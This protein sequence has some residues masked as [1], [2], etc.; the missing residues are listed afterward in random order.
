MSDKGV[1]HGITDS[2]LDEYSEMIRQEGGDIVLVYTGA[3]DQWGKNEDVRTNFSYLEP[4]AAQWLVDHGVKCVGIDSFS[5]EKY[6]FQR[7]LTHEKLLSNGVR[8]IEG[9]SL[10]LKEFVE[11]RMFLVCLPLPLKGIDGSPARPVLFDML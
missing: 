2:D 9:I 4:S 3:S 7:G 11:R 5:M 6:G 10:K 1:G 8:I